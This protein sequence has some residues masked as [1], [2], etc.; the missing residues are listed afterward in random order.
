MAESVAVLPVSHV[1]EALTVDR[2]SLFRG[3]ALWISRVERTAAWLE[4]L[5]GLL[6]RGALGPDAALLIERCGAV[7]TVG[8]RFALDLV[9]LDRMWRVTRV[10]RDVPSGRLMVYGGWSAVRVVECEAGCV[11]FSGLRAGSELTWNQI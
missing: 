9:F 3:G 6:G 5:R 1:L 7:H 10:V 11:D 2:G 8:M 4:R